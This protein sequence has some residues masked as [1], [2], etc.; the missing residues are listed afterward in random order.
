MEHAPR[1]TWVRIGNR[2]PDLKHDP[3]R[4][5]ALDRGEEVG[6][7]KLLGR[8]R[9]AGSWYWSM[10]LTHPGPAFRRPTNGTM[11]TRKE[12]AVALCACYG[13]FRA[14]FGIAD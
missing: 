8:G 14:W 5:V 6:V 7:V 4:F 9:D 11:P 1:L 10:W 12:A 13:A 2:Y 3:D